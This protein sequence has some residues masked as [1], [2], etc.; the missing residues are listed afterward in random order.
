[1]THTGEG[2]IRVQGKEKPPRH[3]FVMFRGSEFAA[4]TERPRLDLAFRLPIAG[5]IIQLF[6]FRSGSRLGWLLRR[7]QR[8]ANQNGKKNSCYSSLHGYIL[9]LVADTTPPLLC[10]QRTRLAPK[11]SHFP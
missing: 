7:N 3:P 9:L 1:M 6:E 5:K 10:G 8:S 11:P 4:R 2:A